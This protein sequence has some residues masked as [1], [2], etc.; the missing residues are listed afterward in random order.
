MAPNNR[1]LNIDAYPCYWPEAWPRTDSW[2][3]RSSNYQVTFARARDSITRRL[4]LMGAAEV[5]ISTNIPLRRDGLP[6]AGMSE[7]KDPAVAVYWAERGEWKDGQTQYK[8]RVIA[9]DHWR[10]VD[11]N[12][13]AA[14]LAIDALHALKRTGATQVIE[15]AFTGFTALAASNPRRTWREVFEWGAAWA[16]TAENIAAQYKNLALARHPDRGGSHD[17]MTELNAAREQALREATS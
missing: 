8:H 12:M 13:R 9:C 7:P 14:N 3:R 16:V 4:Q 11:E 1:I 15:K 5:V 2:K 17:Q 6:L 10:R